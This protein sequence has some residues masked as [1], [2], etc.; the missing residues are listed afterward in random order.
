MAKPCCSV[1]WLSELKLGPDE[2]E[3]SLACRGQQ[4]PGLCRC[5]VHTRCCG[6]VARARLPLEHQGHCCVWRRVVLLVWRWPESW[7]A[8]PARAWSESA[9]H[10]LWRK[11]CQ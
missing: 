6:E 5:Q 8:A 9:L 10:S 11:A 4:V 3:G 2:T 7:V 1:L